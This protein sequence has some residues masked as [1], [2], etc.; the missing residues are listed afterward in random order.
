MTAFVKSRPGM[1][2]VVFHPTSKTDVTFPFLIAAV[3]N[4]RNELTA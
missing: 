3:G 2:E 4:D 1:A